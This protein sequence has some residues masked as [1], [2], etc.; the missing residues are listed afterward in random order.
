MSFKGQSAITVI[1]PPPQSQVQQAVTF[2]AASSPIDY[3]LGGDITIG[4]LTGD[5]TLAAPTSVIAGDIITFHFTQD[6]TGNRIVSVPGNFKGGPI[7]VGSAGLKSVVTYR[8]DGVSW[9]PMSNSGWDGIPVVVS[10]GG[11]GGGTTLNNVIS[12]DT[13]IASDTSYVAVSYLTVNANLTVNGNLMV[14]G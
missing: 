4:T 8:Y 9:M 10:G 12:V 14:I 13:I 3:S 2:A 1:M 11:G 6:A 7:P 5:L